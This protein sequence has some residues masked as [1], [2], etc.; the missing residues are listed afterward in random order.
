MSDT[1]APETIDPR[2]L[3]DCCGRFATGVTVITTR[4]PTVI[5]ARRSAPLCLSRSIRR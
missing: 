3:R 2:A 1:L 4:T 5:T